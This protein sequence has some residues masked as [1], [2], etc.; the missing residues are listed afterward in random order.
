MK[1][2]K[3][4]GLSIDWDEIS[5]CSPDYAGI[6][7]NFSWIY[8]KGLVYRKESYVSG[9]QLIKQCLQMNKLLMVKV[10]D[11]AQMLKEKN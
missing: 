2:L 7:K 4:L 3:L 9:I 11:R 1:S 8:D 6:N 5:T 10:G